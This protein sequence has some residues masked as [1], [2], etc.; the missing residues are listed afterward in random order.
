M[1]EI[2]AHMITTSDLTPSFCLHV[3]INA[4]PFPGRFHD[5]T[6]DPSVMTLFDLGIVDG[7]STA[8]FVQGVKTRIFPLHLNNSDLASSPDTTLQASA[9]SVQA[10]AF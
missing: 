4:T 8:I 1:F 5:G 7:M 3:V 2:G 9:D 6:S 10:N